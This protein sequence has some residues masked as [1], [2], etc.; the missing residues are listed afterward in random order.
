MS[1]RSSGLG[2]VFQQSADGRG[3]A[4]EVTRGG[5]S[6]VP[7]GSTPDGSAIVV[8]QLPSPGQDV[9]WALRILHLR[10]PSGETPGDDP[11]P[12]RLD[13]FDGLSNDRHGTIS[14]DGRWLAYDSDNLGEQLEIFVRPFP[15]TGAGVWQ[16]SSGGGQQPHW[17]SDGRELF[18]LALD[19]AMMAVPIDADV[20]NTSR[21]RTGG[22]MRLFA[23]D[24][25]LRGGG[26]IGRYY[27]VSPDGQRFL[28]IRSGADV[29]AMAQIVVVQNWSEEL[30][31]LLPSQ[32]PN[33]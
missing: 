24:Y 8:S 22:A 3:V 30:R 13:G 31:R 21:L 25:V 32:T 15:D 23:G 17:S 5:T 4:R 28:M 1:Q 2:R 12:E 20:E 33:P 29:G 7:T 26:H 19:G 6:V 10:A 18:Y 14:P 11:L 16:V 27:D 9:G